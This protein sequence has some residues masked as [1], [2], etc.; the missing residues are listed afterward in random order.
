MQ[1]TI[2]GKE[3][4]VVEWLDGEP[5]LYHINDENEDDFLGAIYAPLSKGGVLVILRPTH[6]PAGA[7]PGQGRRE[8]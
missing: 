1:A 8:E 4:E 5:M 7:T 3:Y 6:T 2:D